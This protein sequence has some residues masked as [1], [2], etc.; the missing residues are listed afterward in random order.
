MSELI[1]LTADI[2]TAFVENNSVS[3]GDLPSLISTT[4]DALARLGEADAA[5]PEAPAFTPAVTVRKSLASQD[6]LISMIDGKPYKML[7]RHLSGNGLTPEDYR[8]RYNLPADYPMVAPTYA[9]M[10]RDL[11][12]KIGLGRKPAEAK[13]K[14]APRAKKPA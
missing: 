2:V 10:R 7:K 13:P 12:M 4:H 9:R 8:A 5:I 14:R 11:A 3:V 1:T 6:V